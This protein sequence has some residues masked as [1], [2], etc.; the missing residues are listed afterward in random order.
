MSLGPYAAPLGLAV[1]SIVG[2]TVALLGEGIWD[3]LC[4]V[5]LSLT[6]AI[7]GVRALHGMR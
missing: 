4:W 1:L 6:L 2:L 3:V 5:L 7:G